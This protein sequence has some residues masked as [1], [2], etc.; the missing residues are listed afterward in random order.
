MVL[1]QVVQI[2]L[3]LLRKL[4]DTD[5]YPLIDNASK[6]VHCGFFSSFLH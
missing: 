5:I 3:I 4:T 2:E 6:D 1:W